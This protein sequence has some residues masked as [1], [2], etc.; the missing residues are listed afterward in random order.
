MTNAFVSA[1]LVFRFLQYS[2]FKRKLGSRKWNN[3]DWILQIT[4]FNF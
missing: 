1:T 3:Y 2:N 4:N